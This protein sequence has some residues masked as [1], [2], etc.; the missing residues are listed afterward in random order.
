VIYSQVDEAT[1]MKL[2]NELSRIDYLP[3]DYIYNVAQALKRKRK[4]NP[5]LNT[6]ALPGSEVLINLLERTELAIQ[7]NVMASLEI[8]NPESAR[9]V[10][11][12]L[13]S[14]DTLHF[15]RD[16]QLLEVILSLKHDELL[17]FLKGTPAHVKSA[18]FAKSPNELTS[19]LEE[20]LA[21]FA[22]PNRE[23]YQSIE[24]KILNRMK[25]MANDGLINLL[26]TNERMFSSVPSS[27]EHTSELVM[28]PPLPGVIPIKKVAG[29]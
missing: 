14:L 1:R 13:V 27:S 7:R 9:N 18:I 28:P 10:K 17:V 4:D 22:V 6:E 19:E 23:S 11:S 2:L 8:S 26:E 29:W 5:K 3:R 12:K 21:G 24:R 15:L 16:G 20:E 25:V